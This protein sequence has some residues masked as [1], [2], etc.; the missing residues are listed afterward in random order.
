MKKIMVL[1]SLLTVSSAQAGRT[2]ENLKGFK[3]VCVNAAFEEKG[4]ENESVRGKLITRV[5]AALKKANIP[6]APGECD[7]KGLTVNRQVNLFFDFFTTDDGEI[8]QASLEGWLN[9][10][11]NFKEVTLWNDLYI[12]GMDSGGGSLQA[13]ELADELVADFIADWKKTTH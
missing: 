12:G 13:A 7:V 3:S 4:K 10:E 9:R 8:Y 1:L 2:A 11:G 5:E 6:V